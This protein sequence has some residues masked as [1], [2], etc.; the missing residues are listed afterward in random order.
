LPGESS[1]DEYR[2][3]QDKETPLANA[4]IAQVM[5]PQEWLEEIERLLNEGRSDEAKDNLNQFLDH[6]PDYSI[7]VIENVVGSEFVEG[8]MAIRNQ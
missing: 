6:Y 2:A 8:V 4:T 7:E 1:G 3:P 5:S